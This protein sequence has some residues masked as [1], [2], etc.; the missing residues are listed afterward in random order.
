L[1]RAPIRP[2]RKM[3]FEPLE[4]RVLLNGESA[5]AVFKD[6]VTEGFDALYKEL[7]QMGGEEENPTN[8]FNALVPGFLTTLTH[9]DTDQVV[10]A[11]PTLG[12]AL[13]LL[14]DVSSNYVIDANF[15]AGTSGNKSDFVTINGA[16]RE[17]DNEG[18]SYAN[19]L[20]GRFRFILEEI[21]PN[22]EDFTIFPTPPY[23]FLTEA[24][25]AEFALS[26]MDINRD[27]YVSFAEAFGVLV[28]GQFSYWLNDLSFD[29]DDDMQ[30]FLDGIDDVIQDN[31]LLPGGIALFGPDLGF[32]GPYAD[33]D[34]DFSQFSV[35]IVAGSLAVEMSLKLTMMQADV[36]DFGYEADELGIVL[37]P[38]P[39]DPQAAL[40]Y[41]PVKVMIERSVEFDRLIIGVKDLVSVWSGDLVNPDA[42]EQFYFSAPEGVSID[43]TMDQANNLQNLFVNVGFLGTQA[44]DGSFVKLNMGLTGAAE[45]PSD[46]LPL[47][48]SGVPAQSTGSSGGLD[49]SYVHASATPHDGA[50][51]KPAEFRLVFGTRDYAPARAVTL[52]AGTNL[53]SDFI[54][55]VSDALQAAGLGD[56]V[57]ASLVDGRLY[58][59]L[60]GTN[61]VLMG[62]AA[63]ADVDEN[64]LTAGSGP[65]IAEIK[66]AGLRFL[67]SVG[68]GLPKLVALTAEEVEDVTDADELAVLIQAK[69]D[70]LFSGVTIT[71]NSGN[72]QFYAD[73]RS[74]EITRTM[75]FDRAVHI[76][77]AEMNAYQVFDGQP[78]SGSAFE[79]V[80]NLKA[81]QNLYY[82]D[83]GGPA[84]YNGAAYLPEGVLA[85]TADGFT[86]GPIELFGDA[87][88]AKVV[89]RVP[90]TNLDVVRAT[91]QLLTDGGDMPEMLDFNV[92]TVPEMLGVINQL[93]VWFDRLAANPMLVAYQIPFADAALADL[94]AFGDMIRD[95][96]ILDDHDTGLDRS[97]NDAKL[98]KWVN[99]GNSQY[100]LFPWFHNVQNFIARLSTI[101]GLNVA[102]I[103]TYDPQT[104]ELKFHLDVS[105]N[106]VPEPMWDT[107]IEVPM[108][109]P[110][111]LQPLSSLYTEGLLSLNAEGSFVFTLGLVL[112]DNVKPLDENETALDQL[113]D[114]RGVVVNSNIALTSLADLEPI[115]GRLSSSASFVVTVWTDEGFVQK[116][117]RVLWSEP[118][119]FNSFLFPSFNLLP[120]LPGL[121]T[122]NWTETSTRDNQILANL[123][124]DINKALEIAELDHL[125]KAVEVAD[126][127]FAGTGAHDSGRIVLVAQEAAGVQAF[128]VW[129][130]SGN[131]ATRELGLV[132][133][134]AFTVS[135]VAPVLNEKVKADF[136]APIQFELTIFRAGVDDPEVVP[137][138]VAGPDMTDNRF[139][140]D[141]VID[142]N[143][144]L[145]EAFPQDGE[146]F[147]NPD[148]IAS[149]S[150]DGYIV[151]SAVS[152]G[153]ESF[154]ISSKNAAAEDVLGF[155][156]TEWISYLNRLGV[157][158]T[159]VQDLVAG[160]T[161]R[162]KD[163]PADPQGRL[164]ESFSFF[165][166]SHKV[167]VNA[168]D[169][170]LNRSLDDLVVDLNTAINASDAKGLVIVERDGNYL[171]FRAIDPEV[172]SL[173]YEHDAGS[174]GQIGFGDGTY[175]SGA[176]LK[177]VA[178]RDAPVS[179]GIR[180]GTGIN[181][182]PAEFT[183]SLYI[184][185]QIDPV[186]WDVVLRDSDTIK[187]SSVFEL[188]AR[189]NH[190]ISN[191]YAA[192]AA[193]FGLD[194]GDTPL[195]AVADGDRIVIGLK[196][197]AGSY[198]L[199][200]EV[201][202]TAALV[203]QD[204][205][206]S[207]T[208]D[209]NSAAA[210]E[211]FLVDAGGTQDAVPADFL[212]VF[213]SG[214]VAKISLS[215]DGYDLVK[216]FKLSDEKYIADLMAAIVDQAGEFAPGENRLEMRLRGDGAG[217]ELVDRTFVQGA[218]GQERFEVIAINGSPAAQGLGILA[219]DT[220]RLEVSKYAAGAE[221]IADGIIQ[222]A[223]VATVDILKRAFIEDA[224]LTA[225]ITVKSAKA[226]PGGPTELTAI[227]NYGFVGI[228][229]SMGAD[230]ELYQ[231]DFS[232]LDGANRL[233]M[234]EM[235]RLVGSA[236][237][238]TGLIG[239]LP[240]LAVVVG[241]KNFPKGL[242]GHFPSLAFVAR[243]DSFAMD[244][245]F[246]PAF[247]ASMAGLLQLGATPKISFTFEGSHL[248]SLAEDVV[249]GRDTVVLGTPASISVGDNGGLGDLAYFDA[250]GFQDVLNAL[251]EVAAFL[252]GFQD[253][254]FLA[255]TLPLIGGSIGEL[256]NIADR[257]RA[258][259]L[260]VAQNPAGGLQLLD[261]ALRQ[262]FGIPEFGDLSLPVNQAALQAY[263]ANRGI[264]LPTDPG[265]LAN[266][267]STQ[268]IGFSLVGTV[269]RF[270]LRLPLG[271]SQSRA[272]E[273]DI[274]D[275]ATIPG[276][277][278]VALQGGA[279]LNL[280]GY[281][282]TTIAFGID[283]DNQH[284]SLYEDDSSIAGALMASATNLTFNAGIGPLGVFIRDGMARVDLGFGLKYESG[285]LDPYLDGDIEAILPV[286]FPDDSTY[287]DD[288]SFKMLGFG[289]DAGNGIHVPT[290]D[291]DFDF[292]WFSTIDFDA[293]NPFN[294]IP[295]M[296][297]AL[298]FLLM[299]MQD[300]LDGNVF[301]I[302][303]PLI[304]D[305]LKDG[306][307]FI[308]QLRRDVLSPIREFTERAPELGLELIQS[309]L[310]GL[311]GEGILPG[312]TFSVGGETFN[313]FA[314]LGINPS[315]AKI[316]GLGLLD[317]VVSAVENA[318]DSAYEWRFA[319]GNSYS[320]AV[321][322]G[323]D[324]GFPA[325]GL[326]L[327][328][329]IEVEINW[330]LALGIGISP[331]HGAYLLIGG[332][333][334]GDTEFEFDV[335][336]KLPGQATGRLGF[337]QV[338]IANDGDHYTLEQPGDL[339]ASFGVDIR[340][341]SDLAS[342]I[343]PFFDIGN[344]DAKIGATAGALLNL[345]L[346]VQFNTDILPD[347]VGALL[348]KMKADFILDWGFAN[349]DFLGGNFDFANS[350]NFVGFTDIGLDLGSFLGDFLGPFVSK[351]AEIT[352][353]FAPVLEAVTTRIPVISDLA[354][355]TITLV[356]LAQIFGEVD[357]GMIYAIADI[358]ALV[359]QIAGAG[360]I[361][362]LIIPLG[363]LTLYSSN[364]GGFGGL[365]AGDL[366][367]PQFQIGGDKENFENLA[368]GLLNAAQALPGGWDLLDKIGTDGK[369]AQLNK[370]LVEGSAPGASSFGFP[371]FDN[372]FSA[373]G[374]LLGQDLT[375]VTY[376]LAPFHLSMTYVQQ[377]PI[378][379]PLF[380]RL[381]GSLGLTID[382]AFGYDTYGVR[383][384][385]ESGATN[386]LLLAAG[387]HVLGTDLPDG[388]GSPVDHLLLVGEIFAGA[389]IN[390]GVASAGVD[391]GLRLEIGF[392]LHDNDGD[393]KIRMLEI[394][395]NFL[396]ELRTNGPVL[397]P[398]A[399]FNVYGELSA[400]LRA[401]IE[402][403]FFEASFEITPPI[404]IVEFAYEF[405][406]PPVLAT[407][408]GDGSLLINVGPNSAARLNGNTSDF[409]EEIWVRSISSNQ[410][411]VWAPSMGVQSSA[412]QVYTV[413][414]NKT[415]YLYGG[416][417]NDIINLSGLGHGIKYYVEAGPGDDQVIGGQ[418]GGTM[419]GGL[420]D[421][422]LIG[423]DGNDL[424][425]G[426]AGNDYI[427]G[428]AGN[429]WIF[430]DDGTVTTFL[431]V[432]D[433]PMLRFQSIVRSD[434]GDDTI[435][436]G[437]DDGTALAGR[438]VIFGGGG[439]DLIFAGSNGDMI[440]GDGGNFEGP[441][442]NGPDGI[443]GVPYV[444]H[445]VLTSN[446]RYAAFPESFKVVDLSK[447]TSSL[448]GAADKI[449][450]G[451][452][453]DTILGGAGDDF[454]DGGPGEDLLSG[455][456]GNDVI[457]G[458]PGSDWLFGDAGDDLIF[459]YRDPYDADYPFPFAWL[460]YGMGAADITA[461]GGD[462]I[463]GG[464]GN[465]FI[466]GQ[467]GDDVIHGN[468]GADILFGDEGKDTIGAGYLQRPWVHANAQAYNSEAG[469]DIIFGGADDDIIDGGSGGDI[470]FGDDGL[471][472]YLNYAPT[473]S[474]DSFRAH[475]QRGSLLRT[476]EFGQ[477]KLV[478]DGDE[479]QLIKAVGDLDRA[480][481]KATTPDLYATEPLATDGDDWISGGDGDDIVFGG[482]GDDTIFGDL[483]PTQDFFGPRP[484]GQDVL[485]GD[486][487]R[488]E[489]FNRRFQ[490]IEAIA[491]A[492]DGNDTIQGNDGNDIAFG[493]G[494]QDLMFGFHDLAGLGSK[495]QLLESVQGVGDHD[496][497]FGDNGRI[498]FNPDERANRITRMFTTPLSSDPVPNL[499]ANAPDSGAN[500]RIYG[501]QGNDVI[502]GGLNNLDGLAPA[503]IRFEDEYLGGGDGD[504]IIVGDQGEILFFAPG[505]LGTAWE[506][507]SGDDFSQ[508]DGQAAEF[509]G[510]ALW[511]SSYPLFL[512]RS[513]ADNQGGR[514]MI[515]GE[516]GADMLI[517]GTAGD[518]MYGDDP[519]GSHDTFDGDDIMLGDNGEVRFNIDFT[520][521]PLDDNGQPVGPPSVSAGRL[522]A[523]IGAMPWAQA[524]DLIRTT[525]VE[526]FT[527]GADQMSGN[528]GADVL[529]GGVNN[530]GI[531]Y[532]YG[533]RASPTRA[534][535][536][537]DG[538]DVLVGDNGLVSF[539]YGHGWFA[540]LYPDPASALLGIR[541]DIPF[542][543]SDRGVLN[544][545]VS[546]QDALGGT[547]IISGNAGGDVAV[548]STGDDIIY[549][550]RAYDWASL[551]LGAGYAAQAGD[552]FGMDL[553]GD[554][555]LIGD[556]AYLLLTAWTGELPEVGE[557]F[558]D[559]R[560]VLESAVFVI[561]STDEDDPANTGG[562]DTIAGNGGN[563][564][565]MGGVHGDFLYGDAVQI[566]FLNDKPEDGIATRQAVRTGFDGDDIILGDNGA[567][568][569]LSQGRLEEVE[570]AAKQHIDIG[571]ENPA[572]AAWALFGGQVEN[573]D[574]DLTTLDLI[575]TEQ[576]NSGGQD[577]VWGGDGHDVTLGGTNSD[578][579]FGDNGLE[580]PFAGGVLGL[581]NNPGATIG[582][583][584][585][586][587]EGNDLM[588]G[589]H[590]RLYPQFSVLRLSD[591]TPG[592]WQGYIHSR[593][594]FAID[595]GAADGGEGD[596]MWGQGGD[597]IML[598]Q[599]GDDRMWG[600]DGDDDMIGGHN[601]RG[602]IDELGAAG[603]IQ[604]SL[605]G[606]I[607]NDLMDGGAGRDVMAGDNA[608]VWRRADGY[609]PRFRVLTGL[610]LY[611]TTPDSIATNVEDV[612]ALPGEGRNNPNGSPG[613][614]I[615]LLDHDFDIEAS[616]ALA[617]R[618][619]RDIMAG[620]A[621]DDV[622]FGQLDDDLMQG[623][624]EIALAAS[625]LPF[626]SWQV[627]AGGLV[628]VPPAADDYATLYFNIPERASDGNDYMEG[629]GGADLMFGGLGQDDMIGGNSSLFGLDDWH[630]RPDG[631]DIMFGGAGIRTDRND[632]GQAFAGFEAVMQSFAIGTWGMETVNGLNQLVLKDIVMQAGGHSRDADYMM[633]D[634]ANIY[635]ILGFTHNG[636]QFMADPAQ[637]N[638]S[639]N[640]ANIGVIK[641]SRGFMA[642]NYDNYAGEKIIVRAM[643]QVDY[644]LGGA[645]Y[646]GGSYTIDPVTGHKVAAHVIPG[647]PD[648]GAADW[649][650]GE[651]G[652]DVMFGMVGSDILFGGAGDDDMIGGY[653][654]DWMSG[655]TGQ[656]GMLGD[657]G[658]IHTSR[659]SA[660]YGEPLNGIKPLLAT[661]PRPKYSDGNVLNE[662]IYT[663]GNIQY[664]M[665]N[666]EH[667]LKK[668]ADLTP[669]SVDPTWQ[670]TDDEY[671]DSHHY[672]FADDILFGGWGSDWMHGG[673]GDDAMSGAEALTDAY[674]T[675]FTLI[676]GVRAPDGIMN[677]GYSAAGIADPTH[678]WQF[679]NID[680]FGTQNPGDV[681]AFNP[682]DVEAWKTQ[683]RLRAG[684]FYYY[685]EYDPL[686]KI[687]LTAQGEL[688]KGLPAQG[689]AHEF[690]LN[691][692]AGEGIFRPGG[693]TPG[694]KNQSVA[695]GAVLDD[696]DD[697]MFG[698]NGNDW[699]VGGTGRDHVYGGWGNDLLNV[700]DDHRTNG[701]LNDTPDTH[702][703]YE[704]IAYGG[705]GRDVLIGNT[706]GD[707]LID[708]V[709]EYNSYLVPFAPFGMAT[710]SR[711][712]QPFLPE[713]L[714]ALSMGDGVDV[715]RAADA[716]SEGLYF[717]P[718][719]NGE[720]FGELGL[721]LQKDFAWQAQ[722]GAPADPQAGNIP[723]GKRDVLRTAHAD[724]VNM[725]GF[726][727]DSG[728][729]SIAKGM[730]QVE[731]VKLGGDALAVWHHDQY[732][733]NY[734]EVTATVNVVKPVAGFKANAYI[735]FDYQNADNFKFAGLNGSTNKLEI[736]QKTANGWVVLTTVN[737]NVKHGTDY[738]LL[739]SVNGTS[740]ILVVNNQQQ[741]SY[742]FA[743]RMDADGVLYNINN[744]MIGLGA[745]NAKAGIG[746][747]R[748]QVV[749]PAVTLTA[750]DDF[751][752]A[753]S[754]VTPLEGTWTLAGDR[755]VGQPMSGAQLALA[756]GGLT[757][758]PAHLLQL[759]TK[760][761]TA[762]MGGI[763]FDQYAT[764][765]F[766]WVAW[767][768][769]TNQVQL[770]HYTAKDGW[771]V[772]K[773]VSMNLGGDVTLSVSLKGTTVSVL[774]NNAAALSHVFNAIV[775]DGHFGLFSKGGGAASFD[776]FKVVTDDP[777][778][779]PPS[780]SNMTAAF[781]GSGI[782]V[783]TLDAGS[784]DTIAQA[785][786][787][788]W[789]LILGAMPT[790]FYGFEFVIADLGGLALAR[791]EGKTITVDGDA[792]GH[793][794]FVDPTPYDDGEF[795]VRTADGLRA[796]PSSEAFGK[797]DLLTV[798]MHE[799]GHAIG[800]QHDASVPGATSLMAE[801]LVPG[802]RAIDFVPPGQRAGDAGAGLEQWVGDQPLLVNGQRSASL[803]T[804]T[805]SWDAEKGAFVQDQSVWQNGRLF[806]YLSDGSAA[807]AGE[808]WLADGVE[809]PAATPDDWLEF[810]PAAND[811]GETSLIEWL[812]L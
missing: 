257:F 338:V 389:E 248:G 39:A 97:T 199:A 695:Y 798:L 379:G 334:D 411:E 1:P 624:G 569:W 200:A 198:K 177:V 710:V 767:S 319:L 241:D 142:L 161:L 737:M 744:G 122:T 429:D 204:R 680:T 473:H 57:S 116:T 148:I 415:I 599:Q 771:V 581:L 100:E 357:L 442:N 490:A 622:M 739:L 17:H 369:A 120:G 536:A 449:W 598:G 746:N 522:V 730:Y 144:A 511:T 468:R 659:N 683:N 85:T 73:G 682:V 551:V 175:E 351:V 5:L 474:T 203:D 195:I 665:I 780:S 782:N 254:D 419:L 457:Y 731:P 549:G 537:I 766:K 435:F 306:S 285:S 278:V 425:I 708:W 41:Q 374:L 493:G 456:T 147:R 246:E 395:T 646:H 803:G 79:A 143:R 466:R 231:G 106:L 703:R 620:G 720:P 734:F 674:V 797:M 583:V 197:Q 588:F 741:V 270:D 247:P 556:N 178:T 463:E 182:V 698:D 410:V 477:H 344:L 482:G 494:G 548:G 440:L 631:S 661:D 638:E 809:E 94:L 418:S 220:S 223:R 525:D 697:V 745:D 409:G 157:D 333:E 755:L 678:P 275:Y 573:W 132:T 504:D 98:L 189:I 345:G 123:I 404:V 158:T 311:L 626:L 679:L 312:D 140:S 757:V 417:G 643:E 184:T 589:D 316:P 308:N 337:L 615:T 621:G 18:A 464:D 287:I 762:G 75:S 529:F 380:A 118:S 352:E 628:Q 382:L 325:L 256:L 191:G 489:I 320:P 236:S 33:L 519:L 765:D 495:P 3:L 806:S 280:K 233:D 721:V 398:L 245:S 605:G 258:A 249:Y 439:Y 811:G 56:L 102:D 356:D 295:L 348:P 82:P 194:P 785:A 388:K 725:A 684:E 50:L 654:H 657:D 596:R 413:G 27:G 392:R 35:D 592:A 603:A 54:S 414:S 299:A 397:A 64:W 484:T 349:P 378:W 512:I 343:L 465:D 160:V 48:F 153:I 507:F 359:Q 207:I 261:Q 402:I 336:V 534:S 444:P 691:F 445:D 298:D 467:G 580:A 781:A 667:Q 321:D 552:P 67:L 800:Y 590:G 652:D 69:L 689:V 650:H 685:D 498:E 533:D 307:D 453:N 642:F 666:I 24:G 538:D 604:A 700:D 660:G 219:S 786:M 15:G 565:V 560:L 206:F 545:I 11:S 475:D 368:T 112:G 146:V 150:G 371:L 68:N 430:G 488:V 632:F 546:F 201:T 21:A 812:G 185:G 547:D 188:A 483:D 274:S 255:D 801:D 670:G 372:P 353:P 748:L 623:D 176:E 211:L 579:L 391:G 455:G 692:N 515:G 570:G 591:P 726:M 81:L 362:E 400:F 424:I 89:D 795:R 293:L 575:T 269:L 113:N 412:A 327:D 458:G 481:D 128:Q 180:G 673:S 26:A 448:N 187:A 617:G 760:I 530:G 32:L 770:G 775:T 454:I 172:T 492:L 72:L 752:S 66:V 756:A 282:D 541:V 651:A 99:L 78:N 238:L 230:Q 281:L 446:P 44:Q 616:D 778:F 675:T 186:Q 313:I 571:V 759:E 110:E 722:T 559:L 115:V 183:V 557:R 517:G 61:A 37:D 381:G 408:R 808:D 724:G 461:D 491:D 315:V 508:F 29:S 202:G 335:T 807:Q 384:F 768:K 403:F 383:Q 250:T 479:S 774:V 303:L 228:Q 553:D 390:L 568:E 712:L 232:F 509:A 141:L 104:K 137:V 663:P 80:L 656:D 393:G 237:D 297:D 810:A 606:V 107:G 630:Q 167:D 423:G 754:L 4:P 292:D 127:Q 655:G 625:G 608:I 723:G 672:P 469:A 709:G 531:D 131:S 96:L 514:D 14:V 28:L 779:A 396:H 304:G 294:S 420:G 518:D 738:N 376:D 63:E 314:M 636:T 451:A 715:S 597:D 805:W 65:D 226:K 540:A 272:I 524:I 145:G 95:T 240:S 751:S 627:L 134:S 6:S 576:P 2:I 637:Q 30:D 686:R 19:S 323:F 668:S 735:V 550:D 784:L 687:M 676:D 544:L 499:P 346:V 671:P 416:K 487:G 363:D 794:W 694:N 443:S 13:S 47:G 277:D 647:Q 276:L 329:G 350:L 154:Y 215:A 43:V 235:L 394:A 166:N 84:P 155:D 717:D 450:G 526:E 341:G 229:L 733:P 31:L 51:E 452:G 25:A 283:L 769:A 55:G 212:I 614:D 354:G 86:A 653:G 77:T 76:T 428:G 728:S 217:F 478:G 772:D 633:G 149:R 701:N 641:A 729:W 133:Q 513:W 222:G 562:V 174:A 761:S 688:H 505:F 129:S 593:N 108:V 339:Y 567:L 103:A 53:E 791:I 286:F 681:L 422:K 10:V 12:Q 750:I 152:A 433:L 635:R 707:R 587:G 736:G 743:P 234:Y 218:S 747:V 169:T 105:H 472:A 23:G 441:V 331:K 366:T 151:L 370:S 92:I 49:W 539:T 360:E 561:R 716:A 52:P 753:P 480:D 506:R 273:L 317:G 267:L 264:P 609:D 727:I 459:G 713:Y 649:M 296:L 268:L 60:A 796:N 595:T 776:H 259:L 600:G 437:S 385:I 87:V 365:S 224:N 566:Q 438:N 364:P 164:V 532:L 502:F 406:R 662:I 554:D 619:G 740:V 714:Y 503:E 375:L 607:F 520:E 367:N 221:G 192:V 658:L 59:E 173:H 196:T 242:I 777:A 373:I 190:A 431:G 181:S 93:A 612:S 260:S 136:A 74:L 262:A 288:L 208:A 124:T 324:L 300:L 342:N 355:R 742:T 436:G 787:N 266:A 405:D 45:D 426:G 577:W 555:M 340:N 648:N 501:Q 804:G 763:I 611:T 130:D 126:N 310:N 330:S 138:F 618:Y 290:P 361:N 46:P 70:A 58:L 586:T 159:D 799:L 111:G 500:D 162:A 613:R 434:D 179:F 462:Y 252:D 309:L 291:V 572:L 109:F 470:I 601:V 399:I 476:D 664:T 119:L 284:V 227:G 214:Y 496:I 91:F 9:P 322:F 358:V 114:D 407:E 535:L 171:R 789:A 302:D 205:G 447:I 8:P 326:E 139:F 165:I 485:I 83:L 101:L 669:F 209:P 318:A 386:P 702:P 704:D 792:A 610:Q 125:L 718:V 783:V 279:G 88:S 719:R 42:G 216:D 773:T 645:D 244:V 163:M 749:P 71:V 639:W 521:A 289:L 510:H 706:G 516:A 305:Q 793:G 564:I 253:L 585:V 523:Q 558:G 251:E 243:H 528:A 732:V 640:L 497:L 634:N 563:D 210:T 788:R 213:S 527:G 582:G 168:G 471:V 693:M 156:G 135:L 239:Q 594:F 40:N 265:D 401:F 584:P 711:T 387:F 117:V 7:L 16:D 121:D 20:E 90:G 170:A 193:S 38:G 36:P 34:F 690:L 696:G 347:P 301:G 432:N 602:G 542:A 802:L 699:M 578:T 644:H 271:F 377:F 22:I 543:D 629:N 677:L 421:D 263:L 332:H 574:L 225:D 328:G 460:S 790:V 764:D 62:F 427:V 758:G 705:A 486:G